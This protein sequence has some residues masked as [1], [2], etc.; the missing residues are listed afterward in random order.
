M[1]NS[2]F[3]NAA[4]SAAIA[5]LA[6][7]LAFMFTHGFALGTRLE[8]IAY[9]IRLKHSKPREQHPDI[10]IAAITEDTLAQFPYRSP[11]DRAFLA[12]LL[13]TLEAKGAR[14]IAL[15][16]LLDQPS[17]SEK[18]R[19]LYQALRELRTPL[20]VSYT[21]NPQIVSEAQLEYMDEFVPP[22]MRA[23]ADLPTD[24][25]DGT[26]RRMLAGEDDSRTP[27]S[28]PRKV[29]R[30]VGVDTPRAS[31]EIAWRARPEP[32]TPAFA[33]YPA[34]HIA[35]LPD[36]MIRNRIVLVGAV[37]SL[38][39]RHITPYAV[40]D[41]ATDSTR[42][43]GKMP[44][45]VVQAHGTAQWLEDI[46]T[47]RPSPWLE[48]AV[49]LTFAAIGV[50]VGWLRRGLIASLVIGGT[51]LSGWWWLA[52]T[53]HGEGFPLVPL[54]APTLS[55][56]LSLWMMDATIGAAERRARQ[57]VQAA[58]SRYVS[59]A[60]VEQL[61]DNPEALSVHGSRREATFL[62]TDIAD[63]TTLSE[64]LDAETLSATLNGYLDG[65]CAIILEH[66][67][68]IDKF[69]GD[70]V[71]AIF[72][73]PIEQ[74]DHVSRALDCAL[75]LDAY[76]EDFRARQAASGVSL[77]IT[78]I[79]LHTGVATIGNFGS[80]QRMDFTALGDVVNTASRV[81]GANKYFGTRICCTEAVIR[82]CPGA[83]HRPIGRVQLKG[84]RETVMLFE[85]LSV[86]QAD[87]AGVIAWCAAYPLI[88]AGG[89]E[90][91]RIIE[92][93]ATSHPQDKLIAFY[94]QRGQQGAL[95]QTIVLDDK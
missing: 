19:L 62:F 5:L 32:H 40:D 91:M 88:E 38:T 35:I 81:E 41:Q 44:G 82:Q 84:K 93:L 8:N 39:D 89:A 60:V 85:P 2:A 14:V 20:A 12:T 80:Q 50:G 42:D 4:I 83:A 63:F 87:D 64:T 45:I 37:L 71:M 31:R 7:V 21:R 55:L 27:P 61:V 68:T 94:L 34:H 54:V 47:A 28:F 24:P 13:K 57:F 9:D 65:V 43:D 16:V 49:G 15:D 79:G 3:K 46:K 75:A 74:P 73:A 78:R 23:L 17:E 66:G 6:S 48:F 59:P 22:G 70:A 95:G 1:K 86:K 51:A 92:Q 36:E 76:T 30:L 53:A 67:G 52:I 33:Q 10:V 72:N 29:A 58:F 11:I 26:V 25:F 69:I 56:A 77:G 90:A 18:D